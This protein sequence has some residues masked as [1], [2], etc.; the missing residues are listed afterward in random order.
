VIIESPST[1]VRALY[2]H[3]LVITCSLIGMGFG[4]N[5]KQVDPNLKPEEL[6]RQAYAKAIMLLGPREHTTTELRKKLGENGFQSDVIEAT[7]ERLIK[8]NYQSDERFATLF[9]EQLHRKNRGP[10]SISAKLSS[11]GI[12]PSMAREAI[13]LLNADWPE[14]AADALRLRFSTAQLSELDQA[15]M[16][17]CARFLKSRGFSSTDSIKAIRLAVETVSE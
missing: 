5:K 15:G 11:R 4:R 9:A 12:E 2:N 13:A 16:G 3:A 8:Q 1:S 17:K 14:V 6:A 7:L 10:M